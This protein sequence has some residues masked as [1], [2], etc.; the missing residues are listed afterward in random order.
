MTPALDARAPQRRNGHQR[1]AAILAAGAAVFREKGYDAATMTEIA[2]R[3]DTA[4]GS[5]YRFFRSKEA[6]ADALLAHY[7]QHALD[8]LAALAEAAP[9]LTPGAMAEALVDF[10]LALQSD[11]S[12]VVAVMDARGGRADKRAQFRAALRAGMVLIVGRMFPALAEAQA[13]AAAVVLLH[14]LKGMAN[15]AQDAPERDGALLVEYRHL[16][17]RYLA[18][19]IDPGGAAADAP[20]R[21]ACLR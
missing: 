16:V 14:T 10:A 9:G 11:R 1:V 7:A 12:F 15:A 17:H 21:P 19:L 6:L 13:A 5:L 18:G 2:A 20:P 8:A 4:F 3:S